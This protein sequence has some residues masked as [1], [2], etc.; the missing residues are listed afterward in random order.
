MRNLLCSSF[1]RLWKSWVFWTGML[2]MAGV[3][4]LS[5]STIY[6]EMQ[7]IGDYFPHADNY[8]FSLAL[9]LPILAAVFFGLFVGTEYSEGTIRNKIAAGHPRWAIYLSNLAVCGAAVSLMHLTAM[10][11][12]AA[13]GFPLIGNLEQTPQA[14][15]FLTA[16][17][18]VTVLALCGIF[19]LLTMLIPR[20]ALAAVVA[21]LLAFSMLMV[22]MSVENSL[23]QPEFYPGYT[24][25]E[26]GAHIPTGEQLPNPRYVSGTKRTVYLFLNDFLPSGQMLQIGK[27]ELSSPVRLPLYSLAILA[28]TTVCGVAV[29]RRMDLK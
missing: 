22:S 25:A 4:L 24:I 17:S 23:S 20:K 10:A 27:Q 1:L 28:G 16:L 5:I 18:L 8:L 29:F 13:V 26:D 2:F 3:S 12:V 7:E 6:R 19:L 14:L 9:F 15:L 11:A 21:L